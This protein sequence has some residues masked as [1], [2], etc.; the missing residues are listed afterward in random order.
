MMLV[1]VFC[2]EREFSFRRDLWNAFDDLK[3]EPI[4]AHLTFDRRLSDFTQEPIRFSEE[5]L[6]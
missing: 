6:G 4:E 2:N 3:R 1:R 5:I